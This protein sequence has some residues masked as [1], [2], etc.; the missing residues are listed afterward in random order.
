VQ[1]GQPVRYRLFYYEPEGVD[2]D[3]ALDWLNERAAPGDTL[4]AG[5]PQWV[6]LRTGRRCVLPPFALDGKKA[7]Q[8]IDSVP[9]KYLLASV[10]PGPYQRFTAPLLTANPNAWRRVWSGARGT[11]EVYERVGGQQR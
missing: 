8:L 9:V 11:L 10:K 4:A 5:D 2:L 1:H 7:Q 3:A 6:Y